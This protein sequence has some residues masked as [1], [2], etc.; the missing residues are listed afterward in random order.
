MADFRARQRVAIHDGTDE[1]GILSS[2]PLFVQLSDG[3]DV[4]L[5]NA[6]GQVAVEVGNT[7]TIQ[8]GGNSITVDGT[9]SISG[10]VAV[11]D[12][13]GSLTVDASDLDIRDLSAAQDNVAISDGTDQLAVNADGSINAVVSATDLD[14]RDLSSATDSVTIADGGG[15]I[16]V[17]GAV[18]VSGT[19]ID[20]RDLSHTTDSI[21]IGDGTDLLAIA[22]DGSIAVTDNGTTLSVDDGGGSL[23][24][25]AT[26]LDVRDL[27]HVSD[28]VKIG[29]GTDLL[30]VNADGSINVVLAGSSDNPV[31]SFNTASAVAKDATSNHD[32]T[33]TAAKTL[34]LKQII[35]AAS[36]AMKVEVQVGPLASLVTKAV[37]FTSGA[38]P[39]ES[40]VFEQP[41]EVPDTS[42]GTVRV[43]RRNDESQAM[44]VY[45]TIIGEEV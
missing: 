28:S 3:T 15:S 31:S 27:T 7:V 35:V 9:V 36:G 37:V 19:D 25:D 23:T 4:A 43:I 34:R 20:I 12:N 22:A 33:V 16:T 30:A 6:S 14:I 1:F 18:T 45:S 44:D 42:T 10:T 32:Y 2:K 40:I 41:I 13:G 24:V 8:D 29:D 11:T 38:K 26:D 39:T 5:I 17:D 21:A